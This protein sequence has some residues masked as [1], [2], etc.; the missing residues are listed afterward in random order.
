MW[1]NGN[2]ATISISKR[3]I[4]KEKGVVV[5]SL[6]EY[7][8]LRAKATPEYFLTG[9]AAERLDKRVCAAERENK[10]GRTRT[11]RSLKDLF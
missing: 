1:Y 7:D 8:A 3:K 5:L 6:K 2:M 11:L 9:V 10:A 4:D